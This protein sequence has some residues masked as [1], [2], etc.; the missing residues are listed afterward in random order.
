M[1]LKK[2]E[3]TALWITGG[4]LLV[5]IIWL[6]LARKAA[7][8]STPLSITLGGS[9]PDYLSYN[10]PGG[11]NWTGTATGLP[12]IPAASDGSSC[13]CS[14]G[15][16][17]FY[18]SLNQM[19]S[20]FQQGAQNAFSTY[21]SDVFS[22]FPSSVTQYFNNPAGAAASANTSQTVLGS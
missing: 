9:T 5:V 21:V 16:N 3:K 22:S 8:A 14:S 13:G 15:S 12:S 18:T 4:V 1:A 19:L 20:A 2:G 10:F 17:G 7:A 6:L 11:G